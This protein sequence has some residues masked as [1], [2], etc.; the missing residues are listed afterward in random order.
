MSS[1]LPSPLSLFLPSLLLA[2]FRYKPLQRIFPYF[3]LFRG[4]RAFRT[5]IAG[6]EY[7]ILP[8]IAFAEG[9]VYKF[10]GAFFTEETDEVP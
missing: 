3:L 1:P 8:R 6:T 2:P 4:R 5:A 9:A 10:A 7:V